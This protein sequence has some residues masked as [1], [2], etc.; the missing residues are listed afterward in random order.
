M[1]VCSTQKIIVIRIVTKIRIEAHPH[2]AVS[3]QIGRVAEI[4]SVRSI[5]I[6]GIGGHF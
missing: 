3:V 4:F 1:M 6:G 5:V 2:A